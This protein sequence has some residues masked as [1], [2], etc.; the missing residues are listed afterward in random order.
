MPDYVRSLGMPNVHIVGGAVRDEL[1]GKAAKDHDFIV[2]GHGPDEIHNMLK[3][4]GRSEPLIVAGKHVGVRFYPKDP[5]ARDLAPDGIEFVPPR[6]ERSTGAGHKDFEIVADA[7]VPFDEDARR[8]DFTVNAIARN[9][10][11]GELLDPLGGAQDARDGVLRVIG[12]TAFRDDPLRIL[13][14]LRLIA[15]HD[16]APTDET[17][18]QMREHGEAVEHLSG[19]RIG[20]EMDKLLMGDHVGK[21]LR[22]ARDTGVLAHVFPE[23]EPTIGFAQESRYHGLTADEHIIDVVQA[24]ANVGA[25]LRVRWA[26]LFHDTGKPESSWRG[27]DGNLHYYANYELGKEA[28]EAVGAAKAGV[29]LDRLS[30][31][32]REDRDAVVAIVLAHMWHDFDK[33]SPRRARKFLAKYDEVMAHDLIDLKRADITGKEPDADERVTR[34]LGKLGEFEQAVDHALMTGEPYRLADLALNGHDLIG[35]GFEPGPKLGATLELLK[36]HVIGDPGLNTKEWLTGEAER[37][38]REGTP[39]RQSGTSSGEIDDALAQQ[40][41][42]EYE[43]L[44][45]LVLVRN[46]KRTGYTVPED[47]LYSGQEDTILRHGRVFKRLGPTKPDFD[48][49]FTEPKACYSN[50][51]LL[52]N[53][54]ESLTYVEGYAMPDGLIPV[55]HAWL[56]DAKGVVHDPTWDFKRGVGYV[57]IPFKLD[58]VMD[59]MH[60]SETMGVLDKLNPRDDLSPHVVDLPAVASAAE[61]LAELGVMDAEGLTESTYEEWLHPRNRLGQWREKPSL[62]VLPPRGS[63]MPGLAALKPSK[64]A[65]TFVTRTRAK[66]LSALEKEWIGLDRKLQAYA[67]RPHAFEARNLIGR[68]KEIT[69]QIHHFHLGRENLSSATDV[70]DVVIVGGG[71]AGLSAAIYAGTEGLDAMLV[72]AG[73]KPGGQAGLSSRIVNLLGFPAGISGKQLG[74]YGL[75]QAERVG[76]QT[77]LGV[78]V[79]SL[80]YDHESREKVMLLSDGTSVRA[81]SV[82]IAGGVQF[83]KID[84]P[85]SDSPDV[86][87]GDSALLKERAAGRAVA[88]VGA[89]N[90]AGQAVLD[91]VNESE[92]VY[93]IARGKIAE[94]M[95][96]YLVDQIEA[97]PRITVY[98]GAEVEKVVTDTAGRMQEIHL[99]DG[100][101][102]GCAALGVFIGTAPNVAWSGVARD[103][104][105]FA[106]VGE[107]DKGALE[108]SV[109]GVYAAG[110]VRAGSIHRVA[111]A[112]AD[113]AHAVS[114]IHGYIARDHPKREA[115]LERLMVM[116]AP[117]ADPADEWA[118][119]VYDFDYDE[120]FTGF[121]EHEPDPGLSESPWH[122]WDEHLH[123]RDHI[124]RFADKLDVSPPKQYPY[125][126]EDGWIVAEPAPREGHVVQGPAPNSRYRIR[127]LVVLRKWAMLNG[128]D[129]PQQIEAPPDAIPTPEHEEALRRTMEAI[130][131]VHGINLSKG[132][133]R[134]VPFFTSD[135]HDGTAGYLYYVDDRNEREKGYRGSMI[136]VRPEVPRAEWEA[137]IAHE[138][139]HYLDQQLIGKEL[140]DWPKSFRRKHRGVPSFLLPD[141]TSGY[142]SMQAADDADHP[143]RPVL[144]AIWQSESFQRLNG[145]HDA[146]GDDQEARL[147]MNGNEPEVSS[148]TWSVHEPY[149]RYL[150]EPRELWARA[151]SQYIGVRANPSEATESIRKESERWADDEALLFAFQWKDD[152]FAPIAHA[153]D[154]FF[155]GIGWRTGGALTEA[156]SEWRHPRDRR[157]RWRDVLG[158]GVATA[159]RRK[160]SVG[161]TPFRPHDE[162]EG[163]YDTAKA[164]EF[165]RHLH[166]VASKHNVTV[167]RTDRVTGVWIGETEPAYDVRVHDGEDGVNRWA[168]EVREQWDQDGVL[169]FRQDRKGSDRL[170]KLTGVDPE[171]AI[172]ALGKAGIDGG[173]VRG[174]DL[175]VIGGDDLADSIETLVELLGPQRVVVSRGH[176]SFVERPEQSA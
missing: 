163:F 172:D 42:A 71:P 46:M 124:G 80:H 52:A 2:V 165:E 137:A 155:T 40:E 101:I 82:V 107:G 58:F 112:L 175:E 84:F 121:E 1:L 147:V 145:Y 104:R 162:A 168:E 135:L 150:M 76:A 75:E 7:S 72:D 95:S 125:V 73:E 85:G 170:F 24:L 62:A 13:R 57:G 9:V 142:A 14:G 3:P 132:N 86:V 97:D 94:R 108:T 92:H 152:D 78:R 117:V 111:M 10:E 118:E 47:W 31:L 34:A 79:E 106:I 91:A 60:A 144:E 36:G 139:G 99:T 17:I 138:I 28:H 134:T 6:T 48:P 59:T 5:E 122:R 130:D 161:V 167:T 148:P 143:M 123:P 126:D 146:K 26:G 166:E 51:C 50:A 74:A 129:G 109:P 33:S 68:Q 136:S 67:G 12:D 81:R 173:R 49:V 93:L 27:K 61:R 77:K 44:R 119:R 65:L 156:Y 30:H 29:A 55:H 89:A 88:V 102:I 11:T 140:G 149:L 38:L 157:G 116:E 39:L 153:F 53:A 160:L 128:T 23:F 54:D 18:A 4:H 96:S 45:Y 141:G 159:R 120:P 158:L 87:Y 64:A 110:D 90:S 154:E 15:Q 32:A 83:R 113:G 169:L 19:E 127:D 43:I 176:L 69:R 63:Q 8:R 66:I 35:L 25:P 164:R 171:A 105:G 21:A 100:R 56:V 114:L 41:R 103:E 115:D 22:L 37:I 98:E 70:K 151:Y 174:R 133:A 131:S 16:L 20:G